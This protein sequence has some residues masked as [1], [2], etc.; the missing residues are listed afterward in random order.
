MMNY[1]IGLL[2]ILIKLTNCLTDEIKLGKRLP[3]NESFWNVRIIWN[4]GRI[5]T[6]PDVFTLKN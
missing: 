2:N 5:S 1:M 4:L 6:N 3:F